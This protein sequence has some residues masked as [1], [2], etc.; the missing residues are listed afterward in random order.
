MFK[1]HSSFYFGPGTG[2]SAFVH[3]YSLIYVSLKIHKAGANL[4][5]ILFFCTSQFKHSL[6]SGFLVKGVQIPSAAAVSPFDLLRVS[7]LCC[8]LGLGDGEQSSFPST[9]RVRGP[10][11][12]LYVMLC[13][14]MTEAQL[15]QLYG[16]RNW[17]RS[18]HLRACTAAGMTARLCAGLATAQGTVGMSQFITGRPDARRPR[19]H[20]NPKAPNGGSLFPCGGH[21]TWPCAV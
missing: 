21:R 8:D 13:H 16:N 15:S 5:Q 17:D 2:N 20:I 6:I 3:V 4:E 9:P 18:R 12:L 7:R 14:P 1:R 19:L 10:C 11:S